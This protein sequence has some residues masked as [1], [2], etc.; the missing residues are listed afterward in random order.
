MT[1]LAPVMF[2]SHGSP[3]FALEPGTAGR[4]LRQRSGLFDQLEAL[5]V[6]SPHWMTRGSYLGAAEHPETIHDFG[7]FPSSLYQ[8]NYPAPGAPV[9]AA[10]IQTQ[11]AQQGVEVRLDPRRGLDHGVWVP[12]MH[13]RPDADLP[14]LPLSL[15][16]DHSPA[17]LLQLGQ[18]LAALRQQGVAIIASGGLTHNLRDIRFNAAV[19][20]DYA[21]RFQGWVGEQVRERELIALQNPA[22]HSPDFERAHPTPE[23][24]LP[25]LIALGATTQQDHLETLDSAIE[26][27]AISMTSYL[28]QRSEDN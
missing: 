17:Q 18:A 22:R 7:G 6:I 13:L 24:Y 4:L 8:L 15:N 14:V 10:E 28:W 2:I 20:A 23:H 5:L 16:V 19:A 1:P 27:R 21:E 9:L 25:L 12:L 26:H 11:L 3:T